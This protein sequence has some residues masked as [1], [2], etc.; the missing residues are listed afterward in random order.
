MN[1]FEDQRPCLCKAPSEFFETFI[2]SYQIL[3]LHCQPHR[4]SL[5]I[6]RNRPLL[7][8]VV[9]ANEPCSGAI[10]PRKVHPKPTRS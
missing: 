5:S 6:D 9:Q 7:S 1:M 3:E 4:D 8:D 2:R 10:H